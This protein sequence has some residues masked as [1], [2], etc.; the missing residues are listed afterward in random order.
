MKYEGTIQSIG[1]L[2]LQFLQANRMLILFDESVPPALR[3]MVVIQTGNTA[4]QEIQP[5]DCLWI[6][7]Q[8]YT[9]E[10]VGTAANRSLHE[11]GHCTLVFGAGENGCVALPGQI[12]LKNNL[13]PR[14]MP[15]DI[16]RFE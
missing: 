3:D 12:A 15:G 4:V 1:K 10:A 11:N 14:C 7:K 16:I 9:V 2:A 8:D 5:G 6:G 13:P